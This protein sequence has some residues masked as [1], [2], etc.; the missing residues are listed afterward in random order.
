MAK[1]KE[2]EDETL[3][4]QSKKQKAEQRRSVFVDKSIRS[5]SEDS[6][7]SLVDPKA[8]ASKR[9]RVKKPTARHTVAESDIE[10]VDRVDLISNVVRAKFQQ[11][12]EF[13]SKTSLAASSALDRDEEKR[14]YAT[15]TESA[16]LAALMV[17]AM[18]HPPLTTL[19]T[20]CSDC[21]ATIRFRT[22]PLPL[23]TTSAR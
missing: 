19:L 11:V 22:Q 3:C 6:A 10:P 4:P 18:D 7:I 16:V 2:L 21:A 1:R 13:N 12:L 20:R 15:V 9:V 14:H 23:S 17:C 5:G 8:K